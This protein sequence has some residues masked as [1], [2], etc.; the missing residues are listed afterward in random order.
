MVALSNVVS[1]PCRA[2][3]QSARASLA[4]GCE[5]VPPPVGVASAALLLP[6]VGRRRRFPSLPASRESRSLS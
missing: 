5:G 4:E 2:M 1:I 6:A 3:F